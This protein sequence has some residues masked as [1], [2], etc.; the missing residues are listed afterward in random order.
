MTDRLYNPICDQ[1]LQLSTHCERHCE[2]RSA[3][4][5]TYFVWP[6]RPDVIIAAVRDLLP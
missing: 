6:D 4:G 5:S 2:P 3:P 1:L